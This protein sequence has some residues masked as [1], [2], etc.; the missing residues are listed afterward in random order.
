M[1]SV[2]TSRPHAVT[3]PRIRLTAMLLGVILAFALWGVGNAWASASAPYFSALPA[4]GSTELQTARSGAVA[5]PLPNG[6]VLIA[7]GENAS[8]TLQSAELFSPTSDTFTALPASGSTELQTP[9]YGAVAAALPN[10][11]V[12]IAGGANGGG[13]LQS[14]ELFNPASDTFTALPASG[15]TELQ[16]A[17]QFAVAAPLPNGEVLIA[18]GENGT[19]G[20]LQ[21]AE[22]FNP[23]SDTF[24]ALPASGSTELQTD[25]EGAVASPLP[26]GEVLIAGGYGGLGA[27]LQSAELF[28]PASDTFTALTASGDTELQT[29]RAYAVAAPLPNGQVL[30][31]GGDEFSGFLQSAELFNPASDTF[32]ALPASGSTELQTARDGAVAAPLPNGQVLIAGGYN[33]SST[34]LQ[35]AELYSSAPEVAAAGGDFGDQTIGEP[36][37]VSVVVVTNVGAQALSISATS[38]RRR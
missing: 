34:Y 33:N 1:D 13:Y 35:S 14:A 27:Y 23:S 37:P 10:G 15:N 11:E 21:S 32:T 6:E 17:R 20:I 24:T 16:T 19:A 38:L 29:T 3:A 7:G 31:A 26:N 18:G 22:L 4:S 5:A 9:R 36:S 28:N 8:N 25:R 2:Q 12:L 30:I